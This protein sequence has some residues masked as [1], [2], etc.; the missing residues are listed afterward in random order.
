M[1]EFYEAREN[2]MGQVVIE[3]PQNVYRA[4]HIDDSEYSERIM[5]DLDENSH[6]TEKNP[7]VIPPRRNSLKQDLEKAVGIWKDRPESAQEIARRIRKQNN[8]EQL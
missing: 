4:Y 7:T 1:I 2:N 3:V 6:L 5:R 8:G